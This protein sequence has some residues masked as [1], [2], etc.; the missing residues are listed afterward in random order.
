LD[1]ASRRRLSYCR[2]HNSGWRRRAAKPR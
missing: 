2:H 1:V